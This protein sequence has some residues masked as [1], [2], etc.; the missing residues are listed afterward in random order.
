MQLLKTDDGSLT[1]F[2]PLHQESYHSKFGA[3]SESDQVYL[4]NSG[5][6]QR[7]SSQT[8][9]S[10]LEIGFGTGFNFVQTACHALAN[11]CTLH[12]T[13]CENFPVS[14]HTALQVLSHNVPGADKLCRFTA[15][16]LDQISSGE[17]FVS[18][19]FDDLITLN[20][21]RV[22]AACHTWLDD[23]F[24]AIYLD[25]FSTKNNPTLWQADFLKK[26][27]SAARPDAILATYCVNGKFRSALSEAGFEYRKLP[28]PAGK[29][30]VLIA[31]PAPGL[32]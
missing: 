8:D 3:R 1:L 23:T 17:Q 16:T 5:V 10:I 26:L 32:A 4:R 18:N 24:D 25:A 14:G 21:Q 7:L 28:G 29:R 13:A 22:D 31:T 20:L 30:E 6:H 11:H 2:D 12:Y 27:Q 15:D 19:S 9:T